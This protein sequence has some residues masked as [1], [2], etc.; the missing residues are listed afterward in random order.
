MSRDRS[1]VGASRLLAAGVVA[2]V[3]L[4]APVVA[5]VSVADAAGLDAGQ[6]VRA[7]R[8]VPSGSMPTLTP[9]SPISKT[10]GYRSP[11]GKASDAKCQEYA[12]IYDSMNSLGMQEAGAGNWSDAGKAFG[13]AGVVES[14]ATSE[15]CVFIY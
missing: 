6:V 14:Q 15:G 5:G 11:G 9:V 8:N 7:G 3:L 13:V 4:V 2:L 10:T 1:L 12:D